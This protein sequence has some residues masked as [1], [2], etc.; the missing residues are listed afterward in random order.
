M[1]ARRAIIVGL[2]AVVVGCAEPSTKTPA[3]VK[4]AKATFSSQSILA[5]KVGAASG[6]PTVRQDYAK[7][8]QALERG[9]GKTAASLVTA[10]TLALYEKCRA[11]AIDA[12]ESTLRPLDQMSVVMVLQLRYL[13]TKNELQGMTGA[14]L[15]AW[16][17][18]KGLLKKETVEGIEI[19]GVE[20]DDTRA[21]ASL[22]KHGQLLGNSKFDFVQEDDHWKLDMLPIIDAGNLT[23]EQARAAT[24]KSRVDIAMDVLAQSYKKPIPSQILKGPLR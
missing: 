11:L 13:L 8:K 18:E 4:A 23:L 10:D 15:F 19:L 14:E 5:K 20:F 3:P 16:G 2:L 6:K 1:D 12:P 9:D 24:G 17:V 22:T 21:A 7:L